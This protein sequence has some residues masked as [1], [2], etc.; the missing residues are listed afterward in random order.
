MVHSLPMWRFLSIVLLS[1]CALNAQPVPYGSNAAVG[2][3]FNHDGVKLY[4]EVYGSGEPLLVI[5][6]NGTSIAAMAPQ[7]EYF[8]KNY[9]VIAMD[10]RDHGRSGDSTGPLTYEKMAADLAALLDHLQVPPAYVIGWSDGA[11]EALLLG[12]KYPERVRKI[13]ATG[14]NLN[15][16]TDALYP[17][18]LALVKQMLASVPAA[19]RGK[20]AVQRTIRTTELMLH[21]PNIE[22]AALR[23]IRAPTLIMAGDHDLIRDEHTLAM[24]HEIP[25]GQLAIFPGATHAVSYQ[26][27]ALFNATVERFFSEPFVKIDRIQDAM[28]V[29]EGIGQ[30]Q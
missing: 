22:L 8:R 15:P 5:H 26:N 9:R 28:K 3:T 6:P 29:L 21:E 2:R 1:A 20:P 16:S 7:I 4:Y 17:E 12:M 23:A 27:A 18:T 10:T 11:I 19:D 30:G 13:A 14:A 25:N 24:F